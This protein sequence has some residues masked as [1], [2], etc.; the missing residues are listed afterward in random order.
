M[1]KQSTLLILL[2]L[3]SFVI[4]AQQ[5]KL[6]KFSTGYS[7]PVGVENCGDT[8]LFIVEQEGKIIIC[9]SS[10]VRKTTPYLDITDR[11]LFKGEQGL[12]GL[13]FD[14]N[15]LKNGFFY[16]NYINK[17]GNTQISR[18]KVKPDN[19]NQANKG[20]EKLILE[21]NQ[22]F[23]NHNGGCTRFGPDGYLYIG[24]GDG[25]SEGDP[26]N[27]SQN[28]MSLLGKML[29]IDVHTATGAYKIPAD[30]PFVDSSNYKPEIWA[31]GL[32]NP[33]RWSFDA[34]NGQMLIGDV[35]QDAWEEVDVQLANAGGHN[36][37]WRC[38]EGKH[39]YNTTGC[40]PQSYYNAPKYEYPHVDSTG[41]DCSIT[42]GFV[43]RG[44]RY[45][46]L[47]G[48]YVFTDYCSG[49]FRLLYR[50]GGQGR[51]RTVYDG[52]DNA[53][54][55]FGVDMNNEMFVCN[56]VNGSIYRVAYGKAQTAIFSDSRD[57]QQNR[58][59]FSPNPSAGNINITYTSSKPEQIAI[60]VSSLLGNLVYSGSRTVNVGVNTWNT[61]L[62]IPAGDYY[63]SIISNS[64]SVITQSLRIQ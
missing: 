39:P 32:R 13:A 10:G 19:A 23:N 62:H 6:V 15:Y 37:G 53:Y 36:Y 63:L 35:G 41:G 1:K 11:V 42:G 3:S 25:G 31:L 44:T 9:D 48:D 40:K 16:V 17:S 7:S 14:P 46:D 47:Y 59:S 30:N 34:L 27:Y 12:L 24:M 5:F 43:Y 20:S 56:L 54:S 8:R 57:A 55:S 2:L 49:L 21:I 51:V 29:R 4:N 38:Y 60:H 45:P 64:G 18:F 58:L 28:T 33:W 22:P 26:N 50:D 61:N 52:D